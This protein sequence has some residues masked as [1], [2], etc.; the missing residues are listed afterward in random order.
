[1]RWL[2]QCPYH[3]NIPFVAEQ[4]V[5]VFKRLHKEGF[6]AVEADS[7]AA[8]VVQ[9]RRVMFN[10]YDFFERVSGEW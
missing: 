7:G 9:G 3:H 2:Q 1:M 8:D 5:E 4:S 10:W 6:E